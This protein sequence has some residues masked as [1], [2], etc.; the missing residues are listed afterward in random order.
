MA[1]TASDEGAYAQMERL[2]YYYRCRRMV[3]YVVMEAHGP[4]REKGMVR[5][6]GRTEQRQVIASAYDAVARMA[7]RLTSAA[8]SAEKAH[9]ARSR[10]GKRGFSPR[11]L[12]LAKLEMQECWI[13]Y[14]L[15]SQT[16]HGKEVEACQGPIINE[17]SV[18]IRKQREHERGPD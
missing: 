13:R 11:P 2:G 5:H 16:Q 17:N 18:Q 3:S 6:Q 15:D 7:S 9:Q 8:G 14:L 1:I 4:W 12:K 10:S